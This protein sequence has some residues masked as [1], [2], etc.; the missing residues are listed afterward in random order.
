[1]N[2]H[3]RPYSDGTY[4]GVLA[5]HAKDR[6]E[7]VPGDAD[8]TRVHDASWAEVSRHGIGVDVLACPRC[9][10]RMRFTPSGV[11]KR[12]IEIVTER[13]RLRPTRFAIHDG[14]LLDAFGY[15]KD[16]FP[17]AKARAPPQSDLD[18]GR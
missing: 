8:T 3:R 5:A 2:G 7:I 10:G 6:A 1:M 9:G 16:P 12:G 14:V 13:D 18:S 4:S 15:R 17:M 11:T